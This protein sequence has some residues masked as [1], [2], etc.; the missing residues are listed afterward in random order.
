MNHAKGVERLINL[1]CRPAKQLRRLAIMLFP[2]W[3]IRVSFRKHMGYWLNLQN[4]VTFN[5]KCQW[6]KLFVR[7]PKITQCADKFLVRDYVS[8]KIGAEHLIP[9]IGVYDSVDEIDINQLPEKFVLKPNHESGEIIICNNKE[10]IDW[11][12]AANCMDRW[13]HENYYYQT[14]EWGYKN[15][16]PKIL[17]EK[18]LEGGQLLIIKFSVSME[19]R[20]LPIL[21]EIGKMVIIK[22]LG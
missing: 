22:K 14:V 21:L 7:D 8:R 18:L 3:M 5:E 6:F 9:L 11:W 4:L 13:L 17:C 2:E 1:Y 15:I 10:Y 12:K 19:N 20:P 16:R